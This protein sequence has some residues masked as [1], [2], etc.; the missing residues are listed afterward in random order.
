MKP[1]AE[2]RWAS[3]HLTCYL[4][5]NGL[6]QGK[7]LSPLISNFA[8]VCAISMVQVN[9]DGLKLNGTHQRLVYAKDVHIFGGSVHTVTEKAE[10]IIAIK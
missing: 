2:S 10:A 6:K 9:R 1:L 5:W 8:V 7:A 3:T 4:F